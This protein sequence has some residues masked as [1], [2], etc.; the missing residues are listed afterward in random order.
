MLHRAKEPKKR[1]VQSREGDIG[2][3][4][5][6]L[7]T[8]QNWII[9]YLVLDT[10]T[11][12][13]GKSV[14]ISPYAIDPEIGD[15]IRL[16]LTR[17]QIEESPLP[18]T[19]LPVSRQFEQQYYAHYGWPMYWQGAYVWGATALP[20]HGPIEE[21]NSPPEEE[22]NPHLR[23][24]ANVTGYYVHATDGDIGH[25]EEF[26]VDDRN[27]SIRYLVIDTVNWWPG[28]KVLLPPDWAVDISWDNSTVRV[29]VDRDTIRNAPEYTPD[30][31]L[32][33]D[34]EDRLYRHYHRQAYWIEE[35]Q[36]SEVSMK[37]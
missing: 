36:P 31:A 30:T 15:I 5:D 16:N 27:W 29:L 14:L 33:R 3:V 11:W 25:I 2:K 1:P 24:I 12:L 34:F 10:G 17:T 23:S 37:L 9:R 19:D 8:D 21:V 26:V 13:T 28:K 20:I 6:F 18:E 32:T 22:G 35:N 4:K 7:F